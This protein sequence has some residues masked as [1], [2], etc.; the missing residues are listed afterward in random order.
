[1]GVTGAGFS[2]T[3][4]LNP[5]EAYVQASGAPL[6]I[7]TTSSDVLR[8]GINNVEKMRLDLE[9]N[10]GI[11]TSTPGVDV[12]GT[13]DYPSSVVFVEISGKA[14]ARCL[15]KGSTNAGFDLVDSGASTDNK[16]VLLYTDGGVTRLISVDDSNVPI[17][18]NIFAAIH[19]NG[20]FGFRTDSAFGSGA[21]VIGIANRATAP[22]TNPSGGGVLY[23]ESGALKYR[24]SS[25]TVTTIAN[26]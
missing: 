4:D 14:F 23:V 12:M 22:T 5:A 15:I 21:G 9:G 8:F 26:A 3:S 20:N 13:Y 2:A 11:G 17:I 1:M 7:R 6:L 18:S 19:S 24:G 10:L 16:R 25:G